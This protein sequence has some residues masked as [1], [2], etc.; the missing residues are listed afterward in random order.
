MT[1]AIK[2]IDLYSKFLSKEFALLAVDEIIKSRKEDTSFDD[3]LSSTSSEYYTPHPMYL[4]YWN[5]VKNE[6]EKI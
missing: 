3:T 6:I 1:P 4:T 2:A 5:L